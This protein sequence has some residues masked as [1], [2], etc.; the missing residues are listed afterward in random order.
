[1]FA[2][3]CSCAGFDVTRPRGFTVKGW[4]VSLFMSDKNSDEEEEDGDDNDEVVRS[5]YISSWSVK[6]EFSFCNYC[7]IRFLKLTTRCPLSVN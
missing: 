7:L 5:P 3:H 4:L 2:G 6:D 1:M